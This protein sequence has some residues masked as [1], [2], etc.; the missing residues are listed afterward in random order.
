MLGA[1]AAKSRQSAS[2][3]RFGVG[4][5]QSITI[6]FQFHAPGS[7]RA[8]VVG[9]QSRQEKRSSIV[10]MIFHGYDD[11]GLAIY[12]EP[13][14]SATMKKYTLECRKNSDGSFAGNVFRTVETR[15]LAELEAWDLGRRSD[16]VHVG[17]IVEHSA[18]SVDDLDGPPIARARHIIGAKNW[19]WWW[20]P[21]T[22]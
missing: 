14:P 5:A 12:K 15:E 1:F 7:I 3:T 4:I 8:R 9:N 6:D 22:W 17:G 2:P 21:S 13:G 20:S 16:S 19:S 11:D 18:L 10:T